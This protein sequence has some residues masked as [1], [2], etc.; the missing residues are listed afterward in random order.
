MDGNNSEISHY[1]DLCNPHS[2]PSW[3]GVFALALYF[4]LVIAKARINAVGDHEC[5]LPESQWIKPRWLGSVRH[6]ARFDEPRF[7]SRLRHECFCAL[8][9][10]TFSFNKTW[11][12]IAGLGCLPSVCLQASLFQRYTY[13]AAN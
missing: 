12:C 10:C 7:E 11:P 2:R 4:R 1:N 13:A 5:R 8:F 9:V 6:G 3:I